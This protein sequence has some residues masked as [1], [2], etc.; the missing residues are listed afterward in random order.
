[1]ALENI[2]KD[3]EQVRGWLDLFSDY[4]LLGII[5]GSVMTY[6]AILWGWLPMK[7]YEKCLAKNEALETALAKQ[8]ERIDSLE[9]G[10][11]EYI[12]ETKDE[13]ARLRSKVEG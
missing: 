8:G 1:M 7:G 10:K 12:Q 4:P 6:F 9:Q 3:P 11:D 5:V 2:P 13:L